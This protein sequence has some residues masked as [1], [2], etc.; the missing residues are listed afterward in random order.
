[1]PTHAAIWID[2]TEARIFHIHPSVA[3]HVHRD[4]VDETTVLAPM[5]HVHRHPKGRSGEAREHPEDAKHYFH[6]VARALDGTDAIL[7]VGP[8]SAKLELFKYLQEHEQRLA[9][10]VVAIETVDH[11]TDLEIIAF[12]KK[13]FVKTDRLGL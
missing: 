11:P 1:M 13:V 3:D 10:K 7:I 12:A 9:P 5:H 2:H 6:Q 4:L 8:A